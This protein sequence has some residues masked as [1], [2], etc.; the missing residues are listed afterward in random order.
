[1]KTKLLFII[2]QFYKGGA[3]TAT[4]NLLKCLNQDLYDIDFIVLNQSPTENAVSLLDEVPSE[5]HVVN[6]WEQ[7]KHLSFKE[8]VAAKL[9]LSPNDVQNHPRSALLYVRDKEYDWAFHVGEWWAPDFLAEQVHAKRKALWIHSDISEALAF[10]ENLYFNYDSSI[11]YYLFV[12]E[13]SMQSGL[14]KYPFL[15][16]KSRCI[17][18]ITDVASIREKSLE[19]VEENYFDSDLPVL[20]TCA[21]L[22]QEKNHR[23]QLEA[24]NILHQRNVDFI[25]LNLGSTAEQNRVEALRYQAEQYGLQGRFLIEGPRANPYKYMNRA[26]AVTV[27]SDYESWSMVITEAKVLGKPVIATKTS[28]A[29]EQ[30][31][32]HKTGLITE[33][34]AEHIAD[35]IQEFLQSNALR[36]TICQNLRNFDNTQEILESFNEL[37]LND[38]SAAS[39]EKTKELLYII[40]DVNYLGGAHVATKLQIKELVNKGKHISIFSTSVPTPEVR[41]ELPGVEFLSWR[42]F[43]SNRLYH[44]RIWDCLF[45]SNLTRAEKALKIKMTYHSKIK[46]DPNTFNNVVLPNLSSLFSQY[47]T[48]CVMSEASS[49]RKYAADSTCKNKIQWIHTDYCTWMNLSEHTRQT[50]ANDA[51]L[52]QKF[53]TIVV[54]T[55]NIRYKFAHMYPHLKGKVVII[56]N[57]MPVEEILTKATQNNDKGN[58]PLHFVTVG[59][60]DFS[61]G[62]DRLFK[63]LDKLYQDG[64]HF[65]WTIVGDGVDF[66]WIS[67]LFQNS[68]LKDCV[69]MVG[70]K[71]N[72]FPY[73]KNADIFALLSNYEGLPNTIYEALILGVPVLA[74][75]V[76]GIASQIK[77]GENGWLVESNEKAICQKLVYL[78]THVEEVY[79]VKKNVE[80]YAYD[81]ETILKYAEEVL[82]STK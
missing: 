27:L 7:D 77:D 28:G 3:E 71:K 72:P 8:K 80:N 41:T 76:G 67:G 22:R 63:V 16:K 37:V 51:E 48:V 40:D 12:S 56:P 6:A 75:N 4:L 60:V 19:D 44:R 42:D 52:Y 61:K 79:T 55:E 1:M 9:L 64:Y 65:E 49:F 26:D 20:L 58:I 25:W 34:N 11:D 47:N 5:V 30:I 21:N 15:Q 78:L 18:N 62:Y 57:L 70:A 29:L 14:K 66:G 74:T 45:D 39:S 17:Y 46:K 13:H 53:D 82:F 24:M 54:L 81:N 35:C 68:D 31:E 50:T 59:R 33:F 10:N 23:R 32:D 38:T 2:S 36:E 69:K 73:V 43:S